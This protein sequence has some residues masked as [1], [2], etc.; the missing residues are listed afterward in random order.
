MMLQD[1]SI[2]WNSTFNMLKFMIQ[3]YVAINAMMATWKFDLCE[4]KLVPIEWNTARELWD[5]LKVSNIHSP[6]YFDLFTSFHP[7]F[8][9]HNFIF[10]S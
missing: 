2:W 7:S 9:G 10:L 3:Y 5:V 1:V 6:F 4:Y 8:Q